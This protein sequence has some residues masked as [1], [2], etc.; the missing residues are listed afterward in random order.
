[1]FRA[2]FTSPLYSNQPTDV[3][4]KGIR[5]PAMQAIID[6]AYNRS[7]NINDHN[8]TELLAIAHYIGLT[9]LEELCAIYIQ[10]MLTLDNCVFLW[11][12]LKQD[13]YQ[14]EL[15]AFTKTYILRYFPEVSARSEQLMQIPFDPFFD[16]INDDRLNVKAEEPVWE[17]CIKWIERDLNRRVVHVKSLLSAIR[18][19]LMDLNVCIEYFRH[20][21]KSLLSYLFQ[22][23]VHKVKEHAYVAGDSACNEIT[24]AAL[25]FMYD[26]NVI[27]V[28][29]EFFRTPPMAIPRLPH[30]VMFI[31]GGMSGGQARSYIEAYDTRADRW[32]CL[33][34]E[35]PLGVRAYHGT[36]V[37]GH[38]IYCIG[39]HYGVEYFNSCSVFD[40][41]AKTWKEVSRSQIVLEFVIFILY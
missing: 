7:A 9:A 25:A 8:V 17:C 5:L 33:P 4:V 35:D 1:M 3:R 26:L 18:L 24:V 16:I 40:A 13:L 2:L 6:F 29:E 28:Q 34:H 11:L 12:E 30:D 41:V 37:I 10:S 15:E 36:A 19:G 22:Y 20:R 14:H 32:I 21:S 27:N 39:G 23:F 31:I 38:Q